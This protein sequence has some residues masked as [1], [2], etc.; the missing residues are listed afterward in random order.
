MRL[1]GLVVVLVAA[2]TGCGGGDERGAR[3]AP[4][5][6]VVEAAREQ[7]DAAA[8]DL[9]AKLFTELS[10]AL[11]E[12]PPAEA[13]RIC[14]DVAQRLT[15][16]TAAR[17]R[18]AVRRT[19]LRLR[20]PANRPDDYE[21]RILEAWARPGAQPGA[22]AEVVATPE[23]G[24]ELRYLRPIVLQPLC[25]TCHGAPEAM[26]EAIRAALRERYPD[27]AATGFRPGDVRGAVSVRVPLAGR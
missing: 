13:V 9:T 21:R 26:P 10:R 15:A 11:V 25:T 7:A 1:L 6:A 8:T 18:I 19:T 5:A 16:D 14:G 4:S 12:H 24:Y 22:H 23:G 20:N 27:D 2:S 17:Q 3:G